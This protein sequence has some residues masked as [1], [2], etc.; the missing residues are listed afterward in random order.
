[1]SVNPAKTLITAPVGVYDVQ[2]VLATSENDVGRLCV[3]SAI[4]M[5]AKYKPV[6][7]SSI[8]SVTG[9]WD[10][11]N[12]TWLASA[13]WWRAGGT[14]GF[15]IE[16]FSSLGNPDTPN[17]FLYKLKNGQLGW[18]YLR[19]RGGNSEAFRLQDFASY[20]HDAVNPMGEIGATTIWLDNQYRFSLDWDMQA[21][22]ETNLRH[23]DISINGTS[24]ANYYFGV[25]MWK[26]DTWKVVTSQN[27]LGTE[28]FSI[29][30]D[31]DQSWIG[32]WNIIPFYSDHA[33][34]VNSEMTTGTYLSANIQEPVTISL[35]ASSSIIEIDVQAEWGNNNT[36]VRVN[37]Y[38]SN[39][40]TVTRTVRGIGVYLYAVTAGGDPREGNL[41]S[42]LTYPDTEA[43]GGD[44][45]NPGITYLDTKQFTGIS[46]DSNLDY[47]VVARADN[48]T[49]TYTQIEEDPENEV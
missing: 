41:I 22:E 33:I 14:C 32:N 21:V 7:Y 17:T 13:T 26:N 38:I 15:N 6:R 43:V 18:T 30:I 1:M 45:D 29:N 39:Y 46:R 20:Y 3:N 37:S 27:T 35:R 28:S 36:T 24:L 42:S 10:S 48:Y 23:S 34:P 49:S 9:Q 4:N 12:K 19:P 44:G 31:A 11:I 47:W 40:N 8:D 16:T 5:W 2:Q 25:F